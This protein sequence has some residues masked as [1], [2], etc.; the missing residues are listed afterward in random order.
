MQRTPFEF[1]FPNL[2]LE[3]FQFH[4]LIIKFNPKYINTTRKNDRNK[5]RQDQITS[6]AGRKIILNVIIVTN[7]GDDG[8]L[9]AAEKDDL[10][11]IAPV[12][13]V[14]AG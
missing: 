3:H 5:T 12:T 8:I 2:Q 13:L 6:G 7:P 4:Y 10:A 1:R 14:W 11:I 9:R